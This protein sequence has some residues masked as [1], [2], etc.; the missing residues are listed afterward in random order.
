MCASFILHASICSLIENVFPRGKYHSKM[1]RTG[2]EYLYLKYL[3]L[4][5]LKPSPMI[6][7][8]WILYFVVAVKLQMMQGNIWM[9]SDSEGNARCMSLILK[10]QKQSSFRRQLFERG[11]CSS[12]EQTLSSSMFRGLQV[13]LADDDSVNRMVTKKL[14]EKLGCQVTAVSSGFQCLTALGPSSTT[15]QLVILDL[16]MPEMDGY[17]V[18]MRIRKFRSRSWPLIIALT[19]SAEENVWERCLQVGMNGL[20]KKPV[21]IQG[22]AEEIRKVLARAGDIL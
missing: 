17:E 9:S 1:L 16:H 10:F 5:S 6:Y 22:I 20:V 11:S 4:T 19:A 7:W 3:G 2:P 12:S 21:L 18:A 13:I 8:T 14:L 15:F